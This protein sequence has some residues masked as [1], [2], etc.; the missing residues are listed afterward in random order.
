[1]TPE[2]WAAREQELAVERARR[3]ARMVQAS[4]GGASIAE[5]A[6]QVGLSP[7]WTGTV[8]RS[9][10]APLPTDGRGFPLALDF[11]PYL[12]G[13]EAG[14]TVRELAAAAGISYG[15]MHRGLKAAGVEFRPRGTAGEE[16][17]SRR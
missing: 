6:G 7:N 5:I 11:R 16:G 2:E 12:L 1:M 14:G 13:Y 3:N 9:N 10:G 17:K 15:A 4:L 8:L